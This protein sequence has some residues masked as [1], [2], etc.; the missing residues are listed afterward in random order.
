MAV[1]ETGYIIKRSY[2]NQMTGERFGNMGHYQVY[3]FNGNQISHFGFRYKRDATKFLSILASEGE[4]AAY[5]WER[6]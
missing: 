6:K 5:L 2:R 1:K 4:E 3:D